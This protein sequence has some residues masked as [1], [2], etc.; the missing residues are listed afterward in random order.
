MPR[1]SF[2]DKIIITG[3]AFP[4][5]LTPLWVAYDKGFFREEGLD[6]EL[7]AVLG[8][9]DSQHP[10]HQ[11]RRE[12]KV[13]FHSPGGSPMFRS[14]RE[15]RDRSD[16]EVNVVSIANRTAHVFVARDD[17]ESPAQLKGKRLGA[18]QK[19]G[20][21]IDA[22]IVLRHFGLDPDN[23]ITWV[24]SRGMPPDT[25]RYR[26]QL[27]ERGEID[28]VCCDPP[29]WNMAVRLGGHRLTSSRD[30][31][32]LPEAGLSTTPVVIDEK[33][34]LVLGMVRATLRGG[35]FARLNKEETIDSILRHNIHITRDLADVAWEEDHN[36]W[37]PLLDPAAYQRKV[38]IYTF[39]WNLPENPVSTYYD[40]HFLKQAC[41]EL[42][43]L[44]SWDP[45]LEDTAP[46]AEP[47]LGRA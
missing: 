40:F 6:V 23:D 44:R 21:S 28:A 14:V 12:G 39:E 47:A 27:F 17:I 42:G 5:N 45:T 36:D 38:D 15:K 46:V 16:R 34:D 7:V 33:P 37:G 41:E 29:H 9:P 43:L 1:R 26:L 20:S 32:T 10:R 4:L 8:V 30:L 11:W 24:D 2:D 3:P 25:E 19:G 18:D 22:R 13:V 31:F 35:E